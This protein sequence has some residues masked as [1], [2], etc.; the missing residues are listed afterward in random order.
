MKKKKLLTTVMSLALVGVV[1]VGG[2][3]AYLSDKSN[4]VKNTFNVGNGYKDDL[5]GHTGLW[6]D[7]IDWSQRKDDPNS[8]ARTEEK[9]EYTDLLP[10]SIVDKDPIFHLT[11]GSTTSYVFAHVDGV[12]DM[13]N[14]YFFTVNKPD[15]LTDPEESAFASQWKPVELVDDKF[16]GWYVYEVNSAAS[17][18]ADQYGVTGGTD[19][20]AMF[21]YV[22][23]A[24]SVDNDQFATITESDIVI[25]GVAVQTANL[26]MEQAFTEAKKVYAENSS[27]EGTTEGEGADV[28]PDNP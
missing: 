21:N 19:M 20:A 6:L 5:E 16:D 13:T 2:T 4:E 18:D 3:L 25:S 22:K 9:N 15:A 10:G 12:D 8:T 1:A 23:L 27:N 7:E 14:H 26:T 28:T 11:E 24:S 17:E